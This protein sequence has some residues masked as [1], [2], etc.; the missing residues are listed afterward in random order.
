MVV[1]CGEKL[2]GDGSVGSVVYWYAEEMTGKSDSLHQHPE[3]V[4]KAGMLQGCEVEADRS[5]DLSIHDTL[6]GSD[7]SGPILL[8]REILRILRLV[9]AIHISA[10]YNKKFKQIRFWKNLMRGAS[11][12][13]LRIRFGSQK[14][15]MR[16]ASQ[17]AWRIVSGSGLN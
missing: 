7:S 10:N 3:L 1:N 16:G 6:A 14:S 2:T 11:I 5:N 4:E 12:D 13:A 15:L 17:D 8:G 9:T